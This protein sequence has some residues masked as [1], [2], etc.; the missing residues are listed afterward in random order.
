MNKL[1]LIRVE[2]LAHL[3]ETMADGVSE[4]P[5]RLRRVLEN[6]VDELIYRDNPSFIK[7]IRLMKRLP[8]TIEQFITDPEYLGTNTYWPQVVEDLKIMCP[9]V[10]VG[11][12]QPTEV[13]LTGAI[14][15]AKTWRTNIALCYTLYCL[16]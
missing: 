13:I 5:V 15:I 16:T 1:D 4:D 7:V 10:W 12:I 11:E 2:T 8:V 3:E 6:A 14:G 9:D